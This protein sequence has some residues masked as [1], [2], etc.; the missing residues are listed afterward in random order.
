MEFLHSLPSFRYRDGGPPRSVGQLCDQLSKL[1]SR[2]HL[3]FGEGSKDKRYKISEDVIVH[4]VSFVT[5]SGIDRLRPSGFKPV[6][7][8]IISRNS[9]DFIHNHG[10]WLRSCRDVCSVARA[11]NIPYIISPRGMVEDWA[12]SHNK[13]IKR[14]ALLLYQQRDLRLASAFHA[15]S[16][17][18]AK[19][20]RKLG[21][22]Q[23]ILL[24]PNGVERLEISKWDQV[25]SDSSPRSKRLLYFSRISKKKNIPSLLKA[26]AKI[27]PVGWELVIA[28]NDNSNSLP[29]IVTLANE[30]KIRNSVSF[31]GPLY[32]EEK[33]NI[34]N[35]SDLFVLPTFSENFG[36]V[37][38]EALQHK[39]PVITTTGTPWQGLVE[40]NCGWWV[41][42]TVEGIRSALEDAIQLPDEEL[43]KMGGNGFRWIE[44][45]FYWEPLAR[46]MHDAYSW[47]LGKGE[48]PDCIV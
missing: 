38:A 20:L 21:L 22:R 16:I 42:P 4:P 14:I 34:F 35:T 12:L 15:T 30:L 44:K 9:I 11:N 40:N 47:I 1:G 41:E 7:K 6:L 3:L 24:V 31:T 29:D 5:S 37:V 27:R 25:T 43:R 17:G 39:L 26:W 10:I 2:T 36:I 45:D 28:G 32:G 48:K 8:C 46:K 19:A 13:W 33:K 23:P 18:E